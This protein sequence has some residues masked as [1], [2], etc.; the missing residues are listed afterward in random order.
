MQSPAEDCS[1]STL[2]AGGAAT[3]PEMHRRFTSQILQGEP[4]VLEC[5]C[6]VYGVYGAKAGAV[7]IEGWSTLRSHRMHV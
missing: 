5:V 3:I 2:Q 6:H 1:A 7:R 4:T